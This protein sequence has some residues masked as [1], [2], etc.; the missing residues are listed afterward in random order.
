ML[1]YV[2]AGQVFTSLDKARDAASGDTD[3]VK[4]FSDFLSAEEYASGGACDQASTTAA[5]LAVTRSSPPLMPVSVNLISPRAERGFEPPYKRPRRMPAT[6]TSTTMFEPPPPPR[7]AGPALYADASNRIK[8][9]LATWTPHPDFAGSLTLNKPNGLEVVGTGASTRHKS[10][11]DQ[12]AAIQSAMR[13]GEF[14]V[15]GER[16]DG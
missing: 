14:P 11:P 10:D 7:P 6:I 16:G 1:L 9:A 3:A 5:C 4:S 13:G 15:D 8:A 2:A 12:D